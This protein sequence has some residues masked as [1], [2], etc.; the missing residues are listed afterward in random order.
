ML[1]ERK[2]YIIMGLRVLNIQV[3]ENVISIRY[4]I[5]YDTFCHRNLMPIIGA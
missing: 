5:V 2:Y 3:L 4:G 1:G